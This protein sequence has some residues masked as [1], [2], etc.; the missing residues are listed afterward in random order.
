MESEASQS[1]HS[2]ITKVITDGKYARHS[3]WWANCLWQ[4]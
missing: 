1:E 3:R 4:V 2:Y